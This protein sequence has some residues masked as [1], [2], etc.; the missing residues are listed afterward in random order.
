MNQRIKIPTLWIVI[1]FLSITSLSCNHGQRKK[2]AEKT[3]ERLRVSRVNPHL[4]ETT[5][6]KPLFLNNYTVWMIIQ[7]G[8]REDMVELMSILKAQK[9]NMI[10]A[11]MLFGIPVEPY[12][13]DISAYNAR[14]FEYD[15][16]GRPDPLRP[17]TTPGNDPDIPGQYDFWDHVDYLIDLAAS[18]GMYISL[19]PTWGNWVSGGWSGPAPGDKI[20]F[21]KANAYQY[22]LWLGERYGGK[23]NL[24][25][26]LGGD[27]CATYNLEDV[28]F[29]F[30]EVWR[31]MAEGLADGANGGENQDGDADYNH[32]LISYHST[33]WKPNS[34]EWFHNDPWLAFN[35]IQ[36]TPYDQVESIPYD[37]N[38]AP[39]KPTWLFEGV[40]EE[41]R[42]S[43]WGSRYQ[44]YQT[45]FAGGFGHTYGSS[46]YNFPPDG[47][48]EL[49]M[50][51]GARQMAHLY[52]VTRKIWTDAQFLDRVPDQ[53]LIIGD[54]GNTYRSGEWDLKGNKLDNPGYSDRITAIRGGNGGW[55]MV[56]SAK[57]K[58]II[59]DLSLLQ[60]QKMNVYWFNPRNGKWWVNSEEFNEMTPF[61]TEF[62]TGTQTYKFNP[63][64]NPGNNNDWV[65]ILK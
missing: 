25:W 20:I 28:I 8:T 57:G 29:D 65:L 7:N 24:L 36:D 34:S 42:I 52:T 37:Y 15:S 1:S 61:L 2:E 35:S 47:W 62:V 31:S 46:I 48:R 64:G 11:V 38:L 23:K 10:S 44:A 54:Q 63:P 14:A 40:Y 27:R 49:A 17:I 56:Y 9:F 16:L 26:M 19:H 30:R 60:K 12:V 22:G 39:T 43:A 51:P 18:N 58:E 53:N 4:L 59:L 5:K 45:V 32:L 33:K 41:E 50:L 3:P 6:G 21:N 13:S 55:A